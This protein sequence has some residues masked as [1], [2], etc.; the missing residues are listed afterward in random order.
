MHEINRAAGI[1]LQLLCL[2]FELIESRD[3]DRGASLLGIK[4]RS[5][6]F[7]SSK[8]RCGVP[9]FQLTLPFQ[10]GAQEI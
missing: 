9:N 3:P 2:P 4:A 6:N 1:E 7:D 8:I 10:Q 5:M